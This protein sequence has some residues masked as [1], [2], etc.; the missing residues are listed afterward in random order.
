MLVKPDI[1]D[2]DQNRFRFLN[3]LSAAFAKKKRV[4]LSG[5]K[6]LTRA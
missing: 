5:N 4:K 2:P 6:K 1:V 3:V